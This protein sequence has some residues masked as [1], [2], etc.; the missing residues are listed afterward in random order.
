[1]DAAR[2]VYESRVELQK[3]GALAQK[4]CDKLLS[5]AGKGRDLDGGRREGSSEPID[6]ASAYSC[7]SSDI[8][9]DYCFGEAFGFL[10]QPT[11]EPNFRKVSM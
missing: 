7:F 8:I 2:K 4:L 9:S 6:I 5:M 3:E 11:F 10:Q 1:M